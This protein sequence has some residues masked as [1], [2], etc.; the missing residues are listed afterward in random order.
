MNGGIPPDSTVMARQSMQKGALAAN[1]GLVV[2][3]SP[4]SHCYFDYY[5]YENKDSQPK[6]IG[7]YLPLE[8]VYRFNPI[9]EY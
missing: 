5:Q 1:E 6:A 7:G 2:I 4:T 9:P 3:M 8:Q